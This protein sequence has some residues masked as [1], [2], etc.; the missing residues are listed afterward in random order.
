MR[1]GIAKL[2]NF[3]FC[4]PLH[5]PFTIFAERLVAEFGKARPVGCI[6]KK[7]IGYGCRANDVEG[8]YAHSL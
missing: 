7:E 6:I 8:L 3:V 1:L 5:S 2:E 4:L